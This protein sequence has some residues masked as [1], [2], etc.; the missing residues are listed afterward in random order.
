MKKIFFIFL[1]VLMVIFFGVSLAVTTENVEHLK[2][3]DEGAEDVSFTSFREKL[4]VAIQKE[5]SSF[6]KKILS[7]DV[8]YSF[9]ADPERKSAAE[10]FLKYYKIQGK[11]GSGFWKD[12][13][14]VMELGCTKSGE[15]F[16]CPYV[17]S[18]WPDKYDSFS[19]V[20]VL[21]EK[22]PIRQKPEFSAKILRFAYFSSRCPL[23]IKHLR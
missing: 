2:P 9:G 12:L 4:R 17:Y 6:I 10:G 20:V 15:E 11:K 3:V 5:D 14:S 16:I 22:I 1:S 7:D 18:K 19:F 8:Q 21:G 13:R 23:I